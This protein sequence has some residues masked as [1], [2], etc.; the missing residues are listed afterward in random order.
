MRP[1]NNL[2]VYDKTI[3]TNAE[4]IL[5][6][7]IDN[8]YAKNQWNA[9]AI[10]NGLELAEI[11]D[12]FETQ[13]RRVIEYREWKLATGDKSKTCFKY[14][15][16]GIAPPPRLTDSVRLTPA[17]AQKYLRELGYNVEV[18]EE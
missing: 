1:E 5:N 17:E 13:K 9:T 3:D 15:L 6:W 10:M 18:E 8:G 7:M 12:D 2:V 4:R 14:V 16:D 11:S